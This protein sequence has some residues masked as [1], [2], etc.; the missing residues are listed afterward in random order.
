MTANPPKPK[1]CIHGYSQLHKIRNN[2]ALYN[3]NISNSTS[4]MYLQDCMVYNQN[5]AVLLTAIYLIFANLIMLNIIIATFSYRYTVVQENAIRIA[6]FLRFNLT[7]EY[8]H[9]PAIPPPI[10]WLDHIF[11]FGFYIYEK[12]RACRA[13]EEMDSGI[14]KIERS[15][16]ASHGYNNR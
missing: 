7:M 12:C 3:P 14:W 4:T 13:K 5:M 1:C 6:A 9:I 2:A 8:Y 11:S 10:V 15:F 16:F